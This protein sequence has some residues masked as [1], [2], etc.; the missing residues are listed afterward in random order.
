MFVLIL[1]RLSMTPLLGLCGSPWSLVLVPWSSCPWLI[2]PLSCL[3]LSSTPCHKALSAGQKGKGWHKAAARLQSENFFTHVEIIS[4]SEIENFLT[5]VISP[6]CEE[7]L[8]AEDGLNS[9]H[10][11]KQTT[12]KKSKI[13]CQNKNMLHLELFGITLIVLEY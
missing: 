2:F 13:D 8:I 5:F 6:R 9:Q 7:E 4:F 3:T 11:N 12:T 1:P 10:W